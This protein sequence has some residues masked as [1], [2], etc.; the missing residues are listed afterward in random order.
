MYTVLCEMPHKLYFSSVNVVLD[1]G[2]SEDIE[3]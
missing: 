2:G 1:G 3:D